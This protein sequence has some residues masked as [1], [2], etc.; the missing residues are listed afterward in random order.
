MYC[1]RCGTPAKPGEKFCKNCGI[2]LNSTRVSSY[3]PQ[4]VSYPPQKGYPK[5]KKKHAAI[6]VVIVCLL[7]AASITCSVLFIPLDKASLGNTAS[8][9]SLGE[10]KTVLKTSIGAEGEEIVINEPDDALDG[11]IIEVPEGAYE[12]EVKFTISETVVTDFNAINE[13]EVISPLI[14]ID[15]GEEWAQDLIFLTMPFDI[16][17]E[18][19]AMAFY[20][21]REDES[22]EGIPTVD[23]SEDSITICTRHFSNIV[24]LKTKKEFLNTVDVDTHFEVKENGDSWNLPN[25]GSYVAPG[26]YCNGLA[27]TS[28]YYY[29]YE[30]KITDDP[31]WQDEYENDSW[32]QLETP[33]FWEDDKSAI[34]LCS[35]TNSLTL[36]DKGSDLKSRLIDFLIRKCDM[37]EIE[38]NM[39]A[40]YYYMFAFSLHI[41]QQ[42]QMMTVYESKSKEHLAHAIV[43]IGK[44][45]N[46]LYVYDPNYPTDS[47]RSI[48]YY[49]SMHFFETYKQS[50]SR[51]I[52]DGMLYSGFTSLY[53]I[54]RLRKLWDEYESGDLDKY[55]PDYYIS[56]F[57]KGDEQNSYILDTLNGCTTNSNEL[58]FVLDPNFNGQLTVFDEK[59]HLRYVSGGDTYIELDPGEHIFG[60]LVEKEYDG[61]LWWAGFDWVK[62]TI[63]E[64]KKV[65]DCES[66]RIMLESGLNGVAS[67]TSIPYWD[68]EGIRSATWLVELDNQ[69]YVRITIRGYENE[70]LANEDFEQEYGL[71]TNIGSHGWDFSGGENTATWTREDQV[72]A[73]VVLY[74][75]K[76]VIIYND[77][78][79]I[80]EETWAPST[81]ESKVPDA[82]SLAKQVADLYY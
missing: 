51:I 25:K 30:K 77:C 57:E 36:T 68:Y 54:D 71:Q 40:I 69:W 50:N 31:L 67:S 34:Q 64:E 12:D 6:I 76:T 81:G 49:S 35:E 60:F 23:Y 58:A 73:H 70:E 3:N 43:C 28:L 44:K 16:S 15:N 52:F 29:L 33:G 11:L 45:D 32:S 26:G 13:V 10:S 18:E 20:Y 39:D 48:E 79:I 80:L 78:I 1:P 2:A 65:V 59:L 7:V 53:D 27:L 66:I 5:K 61:K 37:E 19:F 75:Q 38:S 56:I 41:T 14:T 74:D 42:P 47:D 46:I 21:D 24:F 82:A 17:E 62:I 55:F 63:G 9:L 22:F 4:P 8:G 72:S